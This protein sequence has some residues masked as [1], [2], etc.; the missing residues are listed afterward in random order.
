[1]KSVAY[2]LAAVLIVAF[3]GISAEAQDRILAHDVYFSLNDNSPAA[4]ERLIASCKKYLTGH[5]GTVRFAVGPIADDVKRDVDD[6]EFNV[7]LHLVF[8]NKAAYDQYVTS[9]RHLK[10][11][12]ENKENTKKVRVFDSYVEAFTNA[13]AAPVASGQFSAPAARTGLAARIQNNTAAKTQI[14]LLKKAIDAY[15]ADTGTYPTTEQGLQAL[16]LLPGGKAS[17]DGWAGPY[18]DKDVPLD[19]W[20]RPFHY[21]YPGTHTAGQPDIWSLGPDG[22][23]GTADDIGSWMKK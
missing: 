4:K 15:R 13:A 17:P 23:D 1:M 6:L 14:G 19:P 12:A 10:C 3:A 7:A 20:Q 21:R 9:E 2:S 22:I 16:R 8:K 11:I 5:P 18:L